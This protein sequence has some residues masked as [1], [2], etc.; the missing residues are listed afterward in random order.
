MLHIVKSQTS[1]PMACTYCH[2]D[3]VILLIEDAVYCANSM[4]KNHNHLENKNIYCL[5]EDVEARG[6]TSLL[7]D[8]IQTVNYHGFVDLTARYTPSITWD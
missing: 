6:L 3:D 4:H 5:A 7:S 2:S 1:V 8:S